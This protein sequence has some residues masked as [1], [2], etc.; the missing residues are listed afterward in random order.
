MAQKRGLDPLKKALQDGR[1]GGH[2]G[3]EIDLVG[4]SQGWADTFEGQF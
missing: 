3:L 2:K 4:F 1:R